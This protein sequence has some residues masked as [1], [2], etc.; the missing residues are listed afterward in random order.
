MTTPSLLRRTISLALLL[1]AVAVLPAC[2]QTNLRLGNIT[3]ATS[4]GPTTFFVGTVGTGTNA[5]VRLFP[6]TNFLYGMK[7][8]NVSI[9]GLSLSNS[10]GITTLNLWDADYLQNA[11]IGE[12]AGLLYFHS[13]GGT[14]VFINQ[15]G[16]IQPTTPGQRLGESS[17]IYT[18]GWNVK[19]TGLN[20]IWTNTGTNVGGTFTGANF[21]TATVSV[22]TI[23]NASFGGTN[24]GG[25]N[26]ALTNFN[27]IQSSNVIFGSVASGDYVAW[28]AAGRSLR[29]FFGGTNIFIVN[30]NSV[31]VV[32][33][34]G[35]NLYAS[36]GSG[37]GIFTNQTHAGITITNNGVSA[38]N[39]LVKTSSGSSRWIQA[40][41]DGGTTTSWEVNRY[42]MI[43]TSN[44]VSATN[45]FS[46]PLQTLTTTS[47]TTFVTAGQTNLTSGAV[48][49]FT[50][51]ATNQMVLLCTHASAGAS[52]GVLAWGNVT[53]GVSVD[54]KSYTTNAAV[55][56]NDTNSFS[57]FIVRA[58]Q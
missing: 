27:N 38:V 43:Q 24:D 50:A 22:S 34:T 28:D 4:T 9:N 51:A 55:N 46:T 35:A 13:G 18:G 52:L 26:A 14:N 16:S 15:N 49:L 3:A 42:A 41:V 53:N 19:L 25:G 40:L 39:K 17:G 57:W 44:T 36:T 11:A 45:G 10:T 8:T 48:T 2:A 33:G 47:N 1:L 20:G 5:A 7:F 56:V 31:G 21:D 37:Q 29:V 58:P 23:T 12:E 6:M 32:Q 54:V 30:S